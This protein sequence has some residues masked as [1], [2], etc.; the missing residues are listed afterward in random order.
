MRPKPEVWAKLSDLRSWAQGG[1]D[2][3]SVTLLDYVSF[4]ATPDLLFAFAELFFPETILYEGRRF[5][6]SG[7]KAETYE[8]WIRSGRSPE[9]VQRVMNHVHISTLFQGQYVADDTA[10]E[11]AHAI[12]QIGTQTLGPYGVRAE[13][14]GATFADFAVTFHGS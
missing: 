1:S 13:V 10:L 4:V 12:A 9:E 5:L 7:F 14:M 3:E 2:P 8:Q 6:A 11:A